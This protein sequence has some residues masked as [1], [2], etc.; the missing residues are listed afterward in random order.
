MRPV[1]AHCH[2]GVGRLRARSGEHAV[3]AERLGVA[4]TLY[5][6]MAMTF[7]L[8]QAQGELRALG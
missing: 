3:A 1:I 7:W 8:E 2:L 5:R 4:A 6:D